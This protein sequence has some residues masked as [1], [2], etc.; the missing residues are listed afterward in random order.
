MQIKT[1]KILLNSERVTWVSLTFSKILNYLYK[2]SGGRG[3]LYSLPPEILTFMHGMGMVWYGI[4]FFK[5]NNGNTRKNCEI[6]SKLTIKYTFWTYLT[7]WCGVSIVDFEQVKAGWVNGLVSCYIK[8]NDIICT[9]GPCCICSEY[10]VV[11]K[12]YVLWKWFKIF[13]KYS[14]FPFCVF[15]FIISE[16]WSAKVILNKMTTLR[17]VIT[18]KR[19]F[20]AHWSF[21]SL[22]Y[23]KAWLARQR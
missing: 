16:S 2:L 17:N 20:V 6:H 14:D 19:Y 1:I 7:H 3:V 15:H 18:E 11:L 23:G 4:Y 5:E 12:V 13:C 9:Q 10:F 21:H 22:M 8:C